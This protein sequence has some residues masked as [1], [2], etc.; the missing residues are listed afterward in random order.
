M[1]FPKTASRE[2]AEAA[3]ITRKR[4]IALAIPLRTR[5]WSIA[6]AVPLRTRKQVYNSGSG[7][8]SHHLL[9]IFEVAYKSNS[10]ILV[11]HKPCQENFKKCVFKLSSFTHGQKSEPY[12][13]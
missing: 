6:L 1:N 13:K 10:D 7:V 12:Q 8:L 2:A 3:L 5:K 9:I 4:S 11:L